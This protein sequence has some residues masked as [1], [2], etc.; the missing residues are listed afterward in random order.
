MAQNIGVGNIERARK[1]MLSVTM[2]TKNFKRKDFIKLRG[3]IMKKG[4]VNKNKKAS[5]A[6]FSGLSYKTRGNSDPFNKARVYFACHHKDFKK[7]FNIISDEILEKENCCIWYR[8]DR[9]VSGKEEFLE[10]LKQMDL[11]VIPVTKNLLTTENEVLSS[12][13]KFATEQKIPVLPILVEA[14]S[15]KVFNEK[16]GDIQY[17]DRKHVD[18]SALT[19]SKKLGDFLEKIIVTDD[20]RKEI[21]DNFEGRI[22]LSYRKCDR[23]QATKLMHIIHKEEGLKYVAVWY[24]EFLNLGE[25][26]NENIEKALREGKLFVMAVTPNTVEGGNYIITTEYP[27]AKKENKIIVPF[28]MV[29]T[30]RKTLEKWYEGIPSCINGND[31]K[32]VA[33]AIL[34][35]MGEFVRKEKTAEQ[36]YLMGS[37]YLSGIDVEVDAEL[38]LKLIENAAKRGS[39]RATCKLSD[40]YSTGNGV[41]YSLKKSAEWSEWEIKLLKQQ[42]YDTRIFEKY[43]FFVDA[44]VSCARLLVY[45]VNDYKKARNMLL[46]AIKFIEG[47]K[48]RCTENEDSCLKDIAVCKQEIGRT[49]LF[50]G[51]MKAAVEY[52]NLVGEYFCSKFKEN[53]T[54]ENYINLVENILL[55]MDCFDV[56][57][58]KSII[59]ECEIL[60]GSVEAAVKLFSSEV[61][62]NLYEKACFKMVKLLDEAGE[63]ERCIEFCEKWVDFS[64][65]LMEE[66][67]DITYKTNFIKALCSLGESYYCSEKCEKAIECF[68]E[69]M[70]LSYEIGKKNIIDSVLREQIKACAFIVDYSHEKKEN[71]KKALEYSLKGMEYSNKIKDVSVED[72]KYRLAFLD[73]IKRVYREMR[74]F[75]D[76][77][78]Y[79]EQFIEVYEMLLIFD[80]DFSKKVE[81]IND[82]GVAYDEL[83][84]LYEEHGDYKKALNCYKKALKKF[85]EAEKKDDAVKILKDTA[86]CGM[87]LYE[88]YIKLN[89]LSNAYE[90]ILITEKYCERVNKVEKSVQSLTSLSFCYAALA[91]FYSGSIK[92]IEDPVRSEEYGKKLKKIAEE[93]KGCD[94][95]GYIETQKNKM[96]KRGYLGWT[97]KE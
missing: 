30:D 44:Y 94:L 36:E 85:N 68:N 42:Y 69:V 58:D 80:N 40:M 1:A 12:E 15:E 23:A 75:R 91:T 92:K 13:L 27:M 21:C 20:L 14:V 31:E 88:I 5:V 72:Y 89:D 82:L 95:K 51:N 9:G 87:K 18:E 6:E 78:K 66:F 79:Y 45:N 53:L 43:A 86:I 34:E 56:K 67:G 63:N 59:D 60:L 35:E 62:K 77:Q 47:Y 25:N 16:F 26:F 90:S 19:Y 11:I 55:K 46:D 73:I 37:A 76:A 49:Y 83:G 3:F 81:K 28:E 39:I 70:R 2:I 61:S 57:E 7:Y 74:K 84:E 52:I 64:R 10:E 93:L 32:A 96:K 48:S 4:S 97:K 17:L 71:E 41:E 54:E 38:G 65:S 8:E 33:K 50:E 24:D 22:F 29:A